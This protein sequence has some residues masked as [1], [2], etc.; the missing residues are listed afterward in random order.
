MMILLAFAAL[1]AGTQAQPIHGLARAGDG[2]SLRIG[3]ASIRLEGIDAPEFDQ[4][5]TRDGKPWP[6][7]AEA[8]TQLSKLVTGRS[9]RCDPRGTDDYGR[10]LARCYAG[11]TDVNRTMVERGYAVAFRK[12][13][14]DYVAAEERAKAAKLGM[15]AGTFEMPSAYRR[16]SAMHRRGNRRVRAVGQRRREPRAGRR[17]VSAG[18]RAII[19]ARASLSTTCPACPIMTRPGPR[20][21]SV[22]K[23]RRRRPAIAGRGHVKWQLVA[24]SA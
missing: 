13:S 24:A 2:D 11:G 17:V 14:S 19:R 7:G 21:C 9:I 18:S 12:Y 5:C 23:R 10:I 16:S 20:R 6:C 1:A 15:W 3:S 4:S 22:L 8:A